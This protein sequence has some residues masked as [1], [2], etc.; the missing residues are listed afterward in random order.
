MDDHE[1]LA[2]RFEEHRTRLRAVAYR[3]LGSLR[4]GGRRRPGSLGAGCPSLPRGRARWGLRPTGRTLFYSRLGLETRP[5]LINGAA[6]GISIRDGRLFSIMGVTVKGGKIV[7]M[8][9]LADPERL[10]RLDPTILDDG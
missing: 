8:D 3:M 6:G 2:E 10:S 1:W 5:A 4:R 9:I 7:E